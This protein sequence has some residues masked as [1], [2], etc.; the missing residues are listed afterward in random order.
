MGLLKSTVSKILCCNGGSVLRWSQR[1]STLPTFHAWRDFIRLLSFKLHLYF[2]GFSVELRSDN[3]IDEGPEL[4]LQSPIQVRM[5]RS[6]ITVTFLPQ[7]E[8]YVK[9]IERSKSVGEI[10]HLLRYKLHSSG[11]LPVPRCRWRVGA[12][13]ASASGQ[14]KTVSVRFRPKFSAETV[15]VIG[16]SDLFLLGILAT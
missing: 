1:W 3:R 5:D 11:F 13:G 16:V 6:P 8:M 12:L 9:S 2:R 15:L 10:S 4:F 14:T 7:N